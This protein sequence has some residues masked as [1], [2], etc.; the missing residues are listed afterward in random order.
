MTGAGINGATAMHARHRGQELSGSRRGRHVRPRPRQSREGRLAADRSGGPRTWVA[1][2]GPRQ[3]HRRHQR[4]EFHLVSFL[5]EGCIGVESRDGEVRERC[6]SPTSWVPPGW[7][8]GSAIDR[9]STSSRPA[10]SK[11]P[12]SGAGVEFCRAGKPRLQ[13]VHRTAP[14]LPG[15]PAP[16]VR[17][18]PHSRL[19]GPPSGPQQL[20]ENRTVVRYRIPPAC[21]ISSPRSMN[22]TGSSP[23]TQ[24]S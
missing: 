3:A 20:S 19:P 24:A 15:A 17:A 1:V 4:C 12:A 10:T 7:R 14:A 23:A 18:N 6:S 11:E 2:V 13:G 21:L 16:G 5:L 9:T 22:T 8:N